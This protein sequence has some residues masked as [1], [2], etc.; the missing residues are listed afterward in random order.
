MMT[1]TK[2]AVWC[3][4]KWGGL[5]HQPLA[6]A[7]L[8]R[9][10][11]LCFH[12]SPDAGDAGDGAHPL[13]AVHPRARAADARQQPLALLLLLLLLLL[14]FFGQLLAS[15][16]HRAPHLLLPQ[17]HLLLLYFAHLKTPAPA[18]GLL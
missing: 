13:D 7:V 1:A 8:L 5:A 16:L 12:V 3:L 4:P 15:P 6:L 10:S 18:A 2:K 11:S 17:P 14:R 9:C